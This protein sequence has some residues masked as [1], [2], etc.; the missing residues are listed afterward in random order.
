MAKKTDRN[1]KGQFIIG[2]P[3]R[4]KTYTSA[5]EFELDIEEYFQ[6]Q[7]NN[8]ILITE[9]HGKDATECQRKVQRPYTIEGLARTLG[10]TRQTL[11]NYEKV[12]GYEPFFA[13]IARS[14]EKIREQWIELGIAGVGGR[15][16]FLKFQLINNAH[17]AD[18]QE[19]DHRSGDRS[20]QPMNII[21]DSKDTG[22]EFE[23]L[24]DG[25][26]NNERPSEEQ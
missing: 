13:I 9:F 5:E 6:D 2:N 17:Y 25:A 1:E 26:K 10:L 24:I 21:V 16:S 19:I 12:K 20:M 22:D 18:K 11:I 23:K 3:G 7:D 14:K 15:D 4:E 8:P